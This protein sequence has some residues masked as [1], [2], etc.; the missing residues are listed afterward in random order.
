MAYV[1][2]SGIIQLFK[3]INLD[4][5]YMH[6]IYFA[7]ESAQ[8]T[9]FSNKVTN[10]FTSQM[11][12]RHNGNTIRLKVACETIADCTYL[13][14]QNSPN[15]KWYYAFIIAVN[16]VNEN[17][18][19]IVYEIDVMQTW[20]IQNGS[21]RPCMVE[22]EHVNDDTIFS[23]LEA[24]PVGSD[25]YEFDFI[26]DANSLG[27]KD[28]V[29]EDYSVV[30]TTTGKSTTG[31]YKEGLFNGTQ[32]TFKRCNDS[33]GAGD[34]EDALDTYLGSWDAE[35]QQQEV[36]SLITFPSF[37]ADTT[38]GEDL[39]LNDLTV[40]GANIIGT[41]YVP[42]NLKLFSYPYCYLYCTTHN[43]SSATYK[44]EYF[45]NGDATNRITNKTFKVGGSSVGGGQI[46]CFPT[47]Y[48]GIEENYE[49][50]VTMS[51][52]P[53][54]AFNYDA[55]QAWIANGGKTR[56]ENDAQITQL[57]NTALAIKTGTEL[58]TGLIGG[59]MNTGVGAVEIME[60]HSM[61]GVNR[62]LHGINEMSNAVT[63]TMSNIA[64]IKE[65]QNKIDYQWKDASYRPNMT[66]G[67]SD[68]SI[69]VGGRLLN[70]Y[71]YN[72]HIK[73]SELT[74]VDDFFSTYGYAIHKVKQ[75]NLTG[76]QY[77]NF[78]K[79]SGAI[80]AGNM[81]SS[82][83]EAIARIFDGGITFWHNGD[84]VGNYRQSVTN[85]SINNPIV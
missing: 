66:V 49:Q 11:K 82:S 26:T 70:F 10:N 46:K 25:A 16:Y 62:T 68:P 71:F 57:R 85:D 53:R 79:T 72:A 20:F 29:F 33:T 5:R 38:Y 13:R 60:Q 45:D 69:M 39:I 4:N 15:T 56:L 48:D 51:D 42:K 21:I 1:V 37:F 14:F 6:T 77:W 9:W 81:P 75:P 41:N 67:S 17:V 43:G 61:Q 27:N 64:D 12:T 19:E 52:F 18:T 50:G 76:R 65:A 44:W 58:S 78:V 36:I 40:I 7:N 31:M 63:T 2:P 74:R 3:G 59:F 84:Q 47:E 73:I 22:R 23:N 34:V 8:N 54:N 35:Q 55:Y 30:I 28:N 24:E 80:I 83:K 32:H